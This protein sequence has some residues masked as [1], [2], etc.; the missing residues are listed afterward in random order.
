[1]DRIA[2]ENVKKTSKVV[3]SKNL[4]EIIQLLFHQQKGQKV[5][6]PKLYLSNDFLKVIVFIQLH[7]LY[8]KTLQIVYGVFFLLPV[9]CFYLRQ[10]SAEII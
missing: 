5:N 9:I 4:L 6:V 1:M 7:I 2:G 8:T 10:Q 3:A